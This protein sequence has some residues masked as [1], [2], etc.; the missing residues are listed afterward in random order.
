MVSITRACLC[1][2][3]MT[4]AGCESSAPIQEPLAN[5]S[6]GEAEQ[7]TNVPDPVDP[8]LITVEQ[9]DTPSLPEPERAPVEVVPTPL[10]DV[11]NSDPVAVPVT[12]PVVP[13]QP[14]PAGPSQL[15]EDLANLQI[16][17]PW[18]E[19]VV[20]DWDTNKPWKEARLEIRRLLG[21]NKEDARKGGIKLLWEYH[22]KND[23]GDGHEYGFDLFLGGEKV[24]AV[25]EFQE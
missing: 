13:A 2:G 18:L 22:S 7:L 16:P 8:A 12:T 23:I 1:I 4:L 6:A 10:P 5:Q 19:S 20:P 3:V 25:K 11:V 15:Q 24:W 9:P 14:E 17:P 21:L